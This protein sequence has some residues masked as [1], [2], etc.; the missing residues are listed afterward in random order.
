[1]V[2]TDNALN[3]PQ[4]IIEWHRPGRRL[5]LNT[6]SLYFWQ[7]EYGWH[8]RCTNRAASNTGGAVLN[9]SSIVTGGDFAH[10][11]TCGAALAPP[12]VAA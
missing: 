11:S 6:S 5:S 12:P 3:S 2:L 9:N 8:Q 1:M 4:T 7:S 10:T